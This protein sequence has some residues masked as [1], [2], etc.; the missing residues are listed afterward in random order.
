MRFDM[1]IAGVGGQGILSIAT[2]IGRAALARRLRLKQSEVHGMAQRGG[3][4]Q[5]HLRLADL[6]IHSDLVPRGGAALILAMEPLEAL[7]YLPWLDPAAGWVV[8]NAEPVRNIAVYPD[9]ETLYAEIRGRPRHVLFNADAI[10]RERKAPRAVNMAMLGAASHQLPF[11]PEEL[12]I[13]LAD[14]FARKG[15]AVVQGNLAVFRAA[16]AAAQPAAAP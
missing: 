2:L 8:A 3:A 16:R 10:A 4:V 6:P 5:A 9:P 1:I 7:R 15:E 13:A 14:Q 11:T 12:E